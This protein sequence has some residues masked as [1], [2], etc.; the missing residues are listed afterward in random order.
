[1]K[2][3][4]LKEELSKYKSELVGNNQNTSEDDEDGKYEAKNIN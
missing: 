1:M 2:I 3:T 4:S